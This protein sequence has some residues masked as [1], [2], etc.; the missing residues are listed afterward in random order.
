MFIETI[1]IVVFGIFI[2]QY[3][4]FNMELVIFVFEVVCLVEHFVFFG[5]YTLLHVNSKILQ[6]VE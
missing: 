4:N 3:I 2:I 5:T 6:I 1:S